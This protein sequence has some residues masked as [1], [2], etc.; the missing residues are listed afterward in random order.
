MARRLTR[1]LDNSGKE[2]SKAPDSP[3]RFQLVPE[4]VDKSV[5][6]SWS[7]Y[8]CAGS[9]YIPKNIVQIVQT[10]PD[11]TPRKP[12]VDMKT[13]KDDSEDEESV[14][15]SDPELRKYIQRLV[16]YS[17]FEPKEAIST[18]KRAAYEVKDRA[19]SAAM[20]VYKQDDV[21]VW[22]SAVNSQES[23]WSKDSN[24]TA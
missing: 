1:V 14:R 21:E 5:P 12:M 20:T 18:A 22:H 7:N 2:T 4:H 8:I 23:I 9:L 19:R 11:Q 16:R 13:E 10:T 17:V 6:E 3:F 15:V 24:S